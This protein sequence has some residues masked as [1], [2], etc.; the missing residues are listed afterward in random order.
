MAYLIVGIPKEIKDYENRVSLV[1]RSVSSFV[2]SGTK[3]IVES[4]A[5]DRS[6]FTDD[7]YSAAGAQIAN[8]AK[9]LYSGSD[10]IVKVK[11]I[12]LSRG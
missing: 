8:S 10:L 6:G 7:E 5:G 1:P 12:Q 9:E 11:E 2:M 4:Q 3:V